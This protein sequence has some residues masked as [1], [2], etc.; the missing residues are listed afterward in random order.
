M[1]RS[2]SQAWEDMPTVP[3]GFHIKT[4]CHGVSSTADSLSAEPQETFT[5]SMI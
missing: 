4:I 1:P 2:S 3:E 5:V